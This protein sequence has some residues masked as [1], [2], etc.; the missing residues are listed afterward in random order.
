MNKTTKTLPSDQLRSQ[1]GN[2][3]IYLFDQILK[4]NFDNSNT[5]LDCGCGSGRNL[6]YFLRN[7]FDVYGVDKDLDILKETKDKGLKINPHLSPDNFKVSDGADLPFRDSSF[8][9]VLSIAVLHFAEDYNHFFKII[10]EMWR[11]LKSRG[12][13]FV[14]Q[15]TT[16][17]I[18]NSLKTLN[19]NWYILPDGTERFLVGQKTLTSIFSE[20]GGTL[21]DP[22]KTTNV[23]NLRSMTTWCI[24]KPPI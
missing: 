21:L 19:N 4:G 15:A 13:L 23:N 18:E 22:L 1:F 24:Q 9:I 12:I 10:N 8:D 14:R 2:I 5:I 16:I 3:D 6:D 11:V 7:G 17:G 20:L